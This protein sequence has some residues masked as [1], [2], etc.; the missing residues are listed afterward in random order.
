MLATDRDDFARLVSGPRV[1]EAA[2]AAADWAAFAMAAQALGAGEALLRTTVASVKQR[3]QFGAAIGSFQ[4]IKHRLADTLT[5]LEFARPLPYGAALALAEE[6]PRA[7][8]D[9][10]RPRSRRARRPV[11]RRGR[12]RSCMGRW[13]IYRRTGP[14]AVAAEDE[15]AAGAWGAPA[16]GGWPRGRCPHPR[17]GVRRERVVGGG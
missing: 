14:V 4:A 17:A 13:G 11:R 2:A 15:A 6:A 7:G 3:T 8:A 16:R 10:R 1:A 12:R 9:V 5:G